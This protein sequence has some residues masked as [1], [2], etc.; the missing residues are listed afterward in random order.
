MLNTLEHQLLYNYPHQEHVLRESCDI[1]VFIGFP[2]KTNITGWESL[3]PSL[4]LH[5]VILTIF[6]SRAVIMKNKIFL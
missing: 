1:I 3:G 5:L 2:L 6:V 4:N